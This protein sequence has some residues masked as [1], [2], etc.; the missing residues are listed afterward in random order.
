MNLCY[1]QPEA[2]MERMV[3]MVGFDH[4]SHVTLLEGSMSLSH[5]FKI[6]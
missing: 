4:W 1:Q 3:V 6:R 5:A 2:V